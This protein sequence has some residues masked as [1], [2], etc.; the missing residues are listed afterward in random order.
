MIIKKC[1][2][3]NEE[4]MKRNP[5]FDNVRVTAIFIIVLGH[6]LVYCTPHSGIGRYCGG[7]GYSLFFFLSALLY[8][9]KWH[10]NGKQRFE[11]L[12]YMRKRIIK[13][14]SSVWPFLAILII[15]F[16]LMG[17]D[18]SPVSAVLNFCFMGYLWKL[19]GNGH[20]W[21]LTIIMLCYM[22]F[23]FLSRVKVSNMVLYGI[24]LVGL[25]F[26]LVLE[27]LGIPG[28]S[29]MTLAICAVLFTKADQVL[30]LVNTISKT[31]WIPGILLFNTVSMF[32]FMN[33][34]FEQSRIAT[35]LLINIIG[36][37]WLI[38][39]MAVSPRAK[40]SIVTFI[41]GISF[42]IYIVHHTLCA[43]PLYSVCELGFDIISSF[44]VLIVFSIILGYIL[45]FISK[46]IEVIICIR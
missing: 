30:S 5:K 40:N 11:T 27:S 12:P 15:L 23:S 35:Y 33:G 45:H 25:V 22:M 36:L 1:I 42:E 3:I 7:G 46:Q 4:K 13:L 43:G 28:H 24:M 2:C 19:P 26:F 44:L 29:F 6:F 10:S 34:L 14:G 17:V 41:S 20:L 8:G 18:F 16:M 21:F 39:F 38:L 9:L 37:S 32:L 31:I